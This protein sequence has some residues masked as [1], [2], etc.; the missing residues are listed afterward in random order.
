M[1]RR[2]APP[3]LRTPRESAAQVPM[4]SHACLAV[5]PVHIG[6][7]DDPS[8]LAVDLGLLHAAFELD[9][10]ALQA[11][12]IGEAGLEYA[13]EFPALRSL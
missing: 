2:R 8:Q 10:S 13:I 5:D 4:P 6:R 7:V 1:R 3:T 12:T 9:D 11:I